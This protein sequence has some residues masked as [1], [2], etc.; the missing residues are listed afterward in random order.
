MTYFRTE[1]VEVGCQIVVE[2]CRDLFLVFTDRHIFKGMVIVGICRS[3]L[4]KRDREVESC[5]MILGTLKFKFTAH[6]L[7]KL[8]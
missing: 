3:N 2:H 7:N 4:F 6:Q 8:A 5:T 1:I